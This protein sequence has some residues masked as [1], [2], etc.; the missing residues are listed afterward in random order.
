MTKLYPL[1]SFL[2]LLLFCKTSAA[3]LTGTKTIP[4]S[5]S[6]IALALADLNTLGV[7][8]GGVVFNIG[9]S[10]SYTETAP[11]GGLVL[12]SATLNASL[13]ASNPLV[14]QKDPSAITNPLIT[15]YTGGTGTPATAV[16]DGIWRIIG[17]DFITING[18]DLIDPNTTNPSTMEYGYG[19][20]KLSLSDGCRNNTINNCVITLNRINNATA[21]ASTLIG[22][23]GI[24]ML[25]ATATAATTALV[26][27]TLAG[28]NSYNKFYNN[29][30][31]NC[32]IGIG[33]NG[34]SAFNDV[35]N[36][37]GGLT[38]ANGNTIQNY[39]GGTGAVNT[40]CGI[41]T[42]N[43]GA[44]NISYNNVQNNNGAGVNHPL[45]ALYGIY[46]AGGGVADVTH[47]LVS[48]NSNAT[49]H[50][51]YGLSVYFTGAYENV[52]YNSVINST[53]T[54][55]KTGTFYAI[56]A[57]SAL[58]VKINNNTISGITVGASVLAWP[59]VWGIYSSAGNTPD[60]LFVSNNNINNITVNGTSSGFITGIGMS[61]GKVQRA[62]NDTISYLTVTGTGTSGTITG[63][64]TA[65]A[66]YTGISS[67]IFN[68]N[69]LHHFSVTQTGASATGNI[70]GFSNSS[71]NGVSLTNNVVH[72]LQANGAAWI[73]GM[74]MY[75]SGSPYDN[76]IGYDT[77]YSFS[78]NGGPVY[79]LWYGSTGVLSLYKNKIYDFASTGANA[80][81]K[82]VYLYSINPDA[83]ISN[84][85][86]GDLRAP[87][88]TNT[89][90]AIVGLYS[91]WAVVNSTLNVYYNTIYLDAVSTGTNFSTTAFYHGANA[92]SN[93][94]AL[95]LKNNILANISTPNGT[96]KSIA[97][98]RSA[99]TLANYL[100]TSNN[101]LFY[102]G[103]PA[104]NKLLYFDAT[105]GRQTLAALQTFV[106]PAESNSVTELPPF[107]STIGS[108][109]T[110]LHINP[111]STNLEES[112]AINITGFTDDYD[113][114]IRQGNAGYTGNGTAPDIGADEFNCVV[115]PIELI[116]FKAISQENKKVNTSW[117]TASEH[118]SDY[119]LVER[120]MNGRDFE[121]LPDTTAASGNSTTI[122]H[123]SYTDFGP[124]PGYSY[125]RLKEV[126]ID[127][128]VTLSPIIK[129]KIERL[130]IVN[131]YPNPSLGHEMTIEINSKD[132][133]A[134]IEVIDNMGRIIRV[135]EIDLLNGK[136]ILT[137]PTSDLTPGQY[138]LKVVLNSK[139]FT[140]KIFLR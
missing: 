18:I 135:K 128:K 13:T 28:T 11:V 64:M 72:H 93:I 79:G 17:G 108:S 103:T 89:L 94:G 43:Q 48:L 75:A 42:L 32:N 74:Y 120:S 111:C 80:T 55:M 101:N 105:T 54:S 136:T 84:N 106:T 107:L 62:Y 69:V 4:G 96:G 65:N 44:I 137:V 29:T 133:H 102:A 15:A 139:E 33:L 41:Q 67:V 125:Y 97:F 8:A 24:M 35:S 12:G 61:N 109:A 58:K 95:N 19:F 56:A 7:G 124:Y 131:I 88:A 1:I 27:S 73:Y 104:A 132:S 115:A 47:N 3:Q 60:S 5:Y 90:Q 20:Y 14:F 22:S 40:S 46:A 34:Y 86:I 66:F 71:S 2:S 31:Q 119:F 37:I 99:A 78:S 98:E 91:E 127:G 118:N 51:V 117:K 70:Y 53:C 113:L 129:V 68:G 122:R 83:T 112:R 63:M 81:V 123:Y 130:E 100:S 57:S 39:G 52:N 114:D 85:Y 36:D 126:D 49:T 10:I 21:T 121:E 9:A 82:A 25:N 138:F 92:V 6:S 30:I 16:Q 134:F 23:I 59:Q 87:T 26:P 116:S 50:A 110:Y 38:V 76:N 140:Q 45:A 77:M